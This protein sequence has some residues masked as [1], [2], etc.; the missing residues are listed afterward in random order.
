MPGKTITSSQLSNHFQS[1]C[2][3]PSASHSRQ[4]KFFFS[5][6]HTSP[7]PKSIV[8]HVTPFISFLPNRRNLQEKKGQDVPSKH[9]KTHILHPPHTLQAQFLPLQIQHKPP[10]RTSLHLLQHTL[11]VLPLQEHSSRKP[12]SECE[13]MWK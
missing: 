9:R 11:Q 3:F 6:V 4:Y 1:Q 2:S 12:G 10:D 8:H 5:A 13:F 7:P